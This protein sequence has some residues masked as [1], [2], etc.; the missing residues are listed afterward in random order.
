MDELAQMTKDF[1][2]IA[3]LATERKDEDLRLLLA[4]LVRRYR[5]RQPEVAEQLRLILDSDAA[6]VARRAARVERHDVWDAPE[7]DALGVLRVSQSTSALEAPVLDPLVRAQ[8]EMLLAEWERAAELRA[9]GLEPMSSAIFTGPP[10]VG[11]TYTARWIASALD[12]PMYSLDLTTVMSSRLGQSGANL[13]S[14]LDFA[15][16]QPAVLFLDE[17]DSIAKRRADESDVGEIKRLVTIMLQELD[18]WPSTSLLLAATNHP[19]LVDPA[20]W[21]RFDLEVVFPMPGEAEVGAAVERYLAADRDTFSGF[22]PA[23]KR[24]FADR[25][26]SEIERSIGSLRKAHVLGMGAPDDLVQGLLH[27]RLEALSRAARIRMAID[28][29]E[30][31]DLSQHQIARLTTVSRDTIRKRA[32]SGRG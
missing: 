14:A 11:K 22:V 4:R 12:L 20:L 5:S 27:G 26:F 8:V 1:V 32:N 29:A 28:L 19:E 24:F 21:R 15:R 16:R 31:T 30:H 18:D 23:L 2:Q 10:G 7:A 6:D 13:R 25:S 9:T 17:I 3:R